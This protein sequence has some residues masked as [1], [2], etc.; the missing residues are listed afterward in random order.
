MLP[1]LEMT[2]AGP[3]AYYASHGDLTDPGAYRGDVAALRQHDVAALCRYIQGMLVHADWATAYGL[4]G[5]LSRETLPVAK[6]L[7]LARGNLERTPGTC[8]DFALLVCSFMRERSV[9]ARVRCGF[10][11]YFKANPY[12]DHW[13]CEF[14]KAEESRWALAD[15][16]IDEL[17]REQLGVR[18]DTA[19]L[20]AG[21]FINAGEAWSMWRAGEAP[22]GDFGHGSHTGAWF[23]RVNLMRDQLALQK[24]E[25]SD[26][27]HWR[28]LS[29]E[30]MVL[31][32]GILAECDRIAAT[33]KGGSP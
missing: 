7:A 14:W 20:P 26:W 3:L 2:D 8:R 11:T 1:T 32:A 17:Q 23:M 30:D 4:P 22:D 27:D 13:V 5:N 25:V 29:G 12:E 28:G 15:A 6:R 33:T 24:R 18:F 16:Q 31:T 19:D 9:P 10:A 21:K